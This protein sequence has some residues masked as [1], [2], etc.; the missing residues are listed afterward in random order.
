M[1]SSRW[2]KIL[3]IL[4]GLITLGVLVY[5][6]P[7]VEARLAWRL[8]IAQTY[9]RG[10]V[11]PAVNIP[12]PKPLTD[13]TPEPIILPFRPSPTQLSPT[14][15]LTS[16]ESELVETKPLTA[17]LALTPTQ[18]PTPTSIPEN[19]ILPTPDWEK[20]DWNNCGPAALSMYLNFYGWEGDQF[21]VSNV[22]KPTREDRNVNVEELVHFSRNY[23]GWLNTQY[24]V[25][26]DIN[27]LK[28]FIAA[29]IPVLIEASFSFEGPYWPNDDLWAAHYLLVTAYDESRNIFTVQDTFHGPNQV[30]SYKTL[31]NLWHPFNRVYILI[32]LPHQEEGV[33]IILGESWDEVA[34]R[35]LA[36]DVSEREVETDPKNAYSWFNLGTNLLYFERYTEAAAAYDEARSIGW[37]QR[38]LRYQFGPFFAY[39]H[40][41]RTD[42]VLI[43][44][45]YALQRTPNSE[46]ALLWRGWARYRQGD[47]LG[48]SEDFNLAL[49]HNYLYQDARY[50]LDYI[51]GQ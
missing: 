15:T 46:E 8:D 41:G 17:T 32:Y 25:G 14:L 19:V 7:W 6:I 45:E 2:P 36:L 5:K 27:L 4:G 50:A 11:H 18:P 42:D 39:F 20:Q 21:S 29:G 43:L 38:M 1:R 22:L 28:E 9:L 16:G 48:A 47:V 3:L 26:G 12:T 13:T 34:N 23:A 10:I 33:K 37:P 40:A 24:R 49:E 44:T 35:T 30:V 31:D 51:S